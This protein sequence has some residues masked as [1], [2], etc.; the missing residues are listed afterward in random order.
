MK[1]RVDQAVST[2]AEEGKFLSLDALADGAVLLAAE[3]GHLRTAV[4]LVVSGRRGG[5]KTFRR[6]CSACFLVPDSLCRIMPGTI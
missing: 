1:V 2:P 3:R 6:D 4:E 5:V